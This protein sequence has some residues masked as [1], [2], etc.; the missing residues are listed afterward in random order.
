MSS[1]AANA[2]RAHVLPIYIIPIMSA[3]TRSETFGLA[4]A[5]FM[6]SGRSENT[7]RAQVAFSAG[8]GQQIL[9]LSTMRTSALGAKPT[10]ATLRVKALS[11]YFPGQSFH[12]IHY[13]CG[14]AEIDRDRYD[15]D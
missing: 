6:I 12:T 8:S 5:L 7:A 1:C 13:A 15:F 14:S 2:T 11:A 9:P 4:N 3:D 10:L